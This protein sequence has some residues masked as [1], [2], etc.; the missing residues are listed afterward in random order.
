MTRRLLSLLIFAAVLGVALPNPPAA[1]AAALLSWS[2]PALDTPITRSVVSGQQN[3]VLDDARDYRLVISEPLTGSG[4]LRVSGGRNVVLVGGEIIVP[5]AAEAPDALSRR[6]LYLKGQTGTVHIEGLRIGGADL[7]EGINLDQRKGATVRFQNVE[8][9]TVHGTQ[10][11]HHADVLQTWAG[12]ERLQID[13]L[14]G[15]TTYQGMFLLPRQHHDGAVQDW[16]FRNVTLTGLPGSGYSLWKEDGHAI[17]ARSVFVRRSDET[18]NKHFWPTAAAWPGAVNAVAASSSLPSGVPGMGY[19]TPGYADAPGFSLIPSPT[20]TSTMPA[21]TA[22]TTPTTAAP[23]APILGSVP[24]PQPAPPTPARGYWMVSADGGVFAFGS[25]RFHGSTGGIRLNQPVVGLAAVG[26]G[27]GYWLVARDGGIF[28]FGQAAFHGS[29]GGLRLNQPIM[30][31]AATPS[32]KGYWLDAR[33]GGIFAF[34]DAAFYGSTGGMRLN[35]PIVGMAATPS[36]KGYWLV[37]EDGGIFAFGDAAFFGST[38][39]MRLSQPITAMAPTPSGRGYWLVA[40]DG[41]IF[42]FGDARFHGSGA[43]Q[44]PGRVTSI[45]STPS[46]KGYWIQSSTGWAGAFGDAPHYGSVK[47]ALNQSVVGATATQ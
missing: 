21:P 38:G 22:P 2:P 36:G 12:P 31:M 14:A 16:S 30:G 33:D 46:G 37:A 4:G 3:L 45:Q 35:Q 17:D 23:I 40:A 29:T 9:A 13:R 10:A 20:T 24:T 1:A 15:T 26:A 18:T 19:V 32:G 6:G 25:A 44:A 5:T 11:G 41:G 34:G 39:A 28:A 42:A 43:G 8:V 7:A 47:G 27:E